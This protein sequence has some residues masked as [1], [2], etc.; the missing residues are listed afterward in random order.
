M[1]PDKEPV[2]TS[3]ARLETKIEELKEMVNRRLSKIEDHISCEP[4]RLTDKFITR[5][6]FGDVPRKMDELIKIIGDTKVLSAK[7]EAIE[8][9]IVDIKEV[10]KSFV[11]KGDI[12]IYLGI[13]TAAFTVISFLMKFVPLLVSGH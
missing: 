3:V 4:E 10:R 13:F 2:E 8:K 12:K 6:E 9:D 1:S 7:V 5:N 11:S